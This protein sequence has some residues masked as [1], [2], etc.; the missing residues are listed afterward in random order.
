MTENYERCK[1]AI[2]KW[3][4]NPANMQR[5]LEINKIYKR[6]YDSWKKASKCYLA[7]LL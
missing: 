1:K 7:I 6:K 3:R 4:Q 5:T 2:M